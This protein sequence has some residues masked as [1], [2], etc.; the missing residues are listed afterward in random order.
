[1]AWS[2]SSIS[3]SSNDDVGSYFHSRYF[4]IIF[5]FRM[6]VLSALYH[7][8]WY[9]LTST[10]ISKRDLDRDTLVFQHGVRPAETPFF[11]VSFNE[12][13]KL[14]LIGA[15]TELISAARQAIGS[16]LIQREE[17][18]YSRTAYQF[19]LYASILIVSFI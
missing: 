5:C 4:S 3:D 8:G 1:M 6:F 14:R 12:G 15:P 7:Q 18:I 2:R 16:S 10:D 13:D 17:W 9:L 11:I 19:K